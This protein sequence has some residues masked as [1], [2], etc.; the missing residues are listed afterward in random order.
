MSRGITHCAACQKKAYASQ[1]LAIKY[2]L[3][4]SRKR[5]VPLRVYRNPAC[6]CIH[7]TSKEKR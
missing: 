7:L 6:G 2:A 5:G 3:R 1:S 4:Y